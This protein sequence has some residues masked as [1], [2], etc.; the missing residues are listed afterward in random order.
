MTLWPGLEAAGRKAIQEAGGSLSMQ[1]R[2][3]GLCKRRELTQLIVD[4]RYKYEE[5]F[6]SQGPKA[7]GTEGEYTRKLCFSS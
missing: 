3:A 5:K 7:K 2:V 4:F 6:G 1:N